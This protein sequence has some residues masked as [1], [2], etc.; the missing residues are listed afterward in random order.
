MVGHLPW[1]T[2]NDTELVILS[3]FKNSVMYSFYSVP[4]QRAVVMD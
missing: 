4:T 3:G 2:L 1:I